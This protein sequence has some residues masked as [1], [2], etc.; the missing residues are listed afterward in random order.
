MRAYV[1]VD[2]LNLYYGALKGTSHKWLDLS[3][4]C[5]Q[6]LPRDDII[7]I[8]YYTAIVVARPDDPSAPT[9]QQF[10]LRALRT[11]PNVSIFFGHFL[12]Q[13]R[14]LPLVSST[15]I[16]PKKA[17][18]YKTEEKGSDVNLAAHLVRDAFRKEFEIAAL[19]TNDSDLLE[20]IRIVRHELG[21]PV[22][23]LNPHPKPSKALQ[24]HAVFLKQIRPRHLRRSQ[25]PDVM[26]DARGQFHKPA[27]W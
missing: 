26:T 5:R 23:I 2:G 22:G 13:A 12:T 9:R 10:Y 14:W 15:R 4:L 7:Q 27:S 11:L 16:P 21:L 20:P 24:P 19:V 8:K 25:F 17:Q 6:L 18:V 1:Y 3:A